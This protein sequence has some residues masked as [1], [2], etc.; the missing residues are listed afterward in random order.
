MKVLTRIVVFILLVGSLNF[1][2]LG[3]VGFFNAMS[4]IATITDPAAGKQ[5]AHAASQEFVFRY[6][7]M[8]AAIITLVSALIAFGA[9]LLTLLVG[10]ALAVGVFFI[11]HFSFIAY[12]ARHNPSAT[13]VTPSIPRPTDGTTAQQRAIR[14]FPDLAVPNSRLNQEFIRRHNQYQKDNKQY[15]VDPEWPTKLAKE[16]NEA[17]KHQ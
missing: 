12:Q 13:Q 10:G 9:R 3:A 2:G 1:G 11:M 15:F 17:I 16:A 8:M 14:L 4:A 6:W 5:A 7:P